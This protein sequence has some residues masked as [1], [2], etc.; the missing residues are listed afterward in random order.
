MKKV[1][2]KT[3]K[4][5]VLLHKTNKTIYIDFMGDTTKVLGVGKINS[6]SRYYV[7]LDIPNFRELP[8]FIPIDEIFY[9]SEEEINI[10]EGKGIKDTMPQ[11]KAIS[12]N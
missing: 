11:P 8:Y 9:Y 12:N 6:S 3:E 2:I 7:L 5:L 10:K 1:Y 4:D